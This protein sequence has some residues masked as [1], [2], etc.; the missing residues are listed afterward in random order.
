MIGVSRGGRGVLEL[1]SSKKGDWTEEGRAD[2]PCAT[3]PFPY[4]ISRRRRRASDREWG[5]G[6]G[7]RCPFGVDIENA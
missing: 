2:A 7:G 5:G 6:R 3:S 1:V 4:G